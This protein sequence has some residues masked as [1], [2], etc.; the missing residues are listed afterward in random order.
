M[1][2]FDVPEVLN[3]HTNEINKRLTTIKLNKPKFKK[4][5]K[6]IT[7]SFSKVNFSLL[8]KKTLLKKVD[9]FYFRLHERSELP[10]HKISDAGNSSKNHNHDLMSPND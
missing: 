1:E 8:E 4:S 6:K 7:F 3:V 5:I 10:A 9:F 2:N